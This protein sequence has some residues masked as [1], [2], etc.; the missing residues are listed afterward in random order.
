MKHTIKPIKE[1]P[2]D[3]L[4]E[5]LLH[6]QEV[7]SLV[8]PRDYPRLP[9]IDYHVSIE[10]FRG[11]V[12]GDHVMLINFRKYKL[13]QKIAEATKSCNTALA[14]K[15]KKNLDAFGILIADVAGHMIGSSVIVNYLHGAFKTGFIYE[16]KHN[17]EVTPELFEIISSDLYNHMQ[18]D[19][20]QVKPYTTLQYGEIHSDGRYKWLSAAH[21]PPFIFSNKYNEIRKLGSDH[22]KASTPLGVLP[23]KFSIDTEHFIS[24]DITNGKFDVNEIQLLGHGDIMLLYTD[25]LIEHSD[26]TSGF[27]D[28]GLEN[29]LRET[30]DKSA[31]EI[32]EAIK[33]GLY[34]FCPPEDDLTLVV[35]KKV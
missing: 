28:T 5:E 30:K 35:I 21:P 4:V 15:L 27:R 29:I 10:P 26:G 25:G 2:K 20:L 31:K 12:G 11:C 32:C 22:T 3:E 23:G 6:L 7:S 14:E 13:K 18:P 17:G 34:S 9:G 16:F 24:P 19:Y 33:K 8:L 1:W